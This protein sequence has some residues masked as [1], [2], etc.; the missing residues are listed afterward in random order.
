MR[1]LVVA[2]TKPLDMDWADLKPMLEDAWKGTT[3]LSNAIVT[4]LALQEQQRTPEMTRMPK[5]PSSYLYPWARKEF[6]E[7]D[8]Q[9]ANALIHTV[10]STYNRFRLDVF[11]RRSR[12][13][14]Q[15]RYPTLAPFPGQSSRLDWLS[16]SDH[17]PVV[18]FRL[19][20]ERVRL[21]LAAHHQ[22]NFKKDLTRII[23]GEAKLCGGSVYRKTSFGSHR[24]AFVSRAPGGGQRIH[25][26]VF[27]KLTAWFP[28]PETKSAPRRRHL[29]IATGDD[30]FLTGSLTGRSQWTLHAQHVRRWVVSHFDRLRRLADDFKYER[31]QTSKHRLPINEYRTK[32]I[33]K[34]HRRLSTFLKQTCA[35]VL[36]YAQRNACRKIIWDRT[37]TG[38]L[39]SFPW[40]ELETMIETRAKEQGIAFERPAEIHTPQG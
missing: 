25:S 40:Y 34:H 35:E 22:K 7:L 10:Q 33:D 36:A 26:Q 37:R 19:G 32:L 8:L 3:Q 4:K 39:P 24:K 20:G 9:C 11:W 15:Y 16:E 13:L 21:Q 2:V 1:S 29:K 14:P 38:F 27:V 31:R 23:D 18:T 5:A 17:V 6:A 28:I 30:C 12:S